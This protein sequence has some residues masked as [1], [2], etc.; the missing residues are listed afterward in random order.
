MAVNNPN[1]I[2]SGDVENADKKAFTAEQKRKMVEAPGNPAA[3]R[4]VFIRRAV[5]IFTFL[6]FIL[7]FF[8]KNKIIRIM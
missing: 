5:Q 4:T 6:L 2:K 1:L 8:L 3:T 7:F